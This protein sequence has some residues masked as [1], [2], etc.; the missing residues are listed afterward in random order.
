MKVKQAAKILSTGL[1]TLMMLCFAVTGL[2]IPLAAPNSTQIVVIMNDVANH[3]THDESKS[4]SPV[5][6]TLYDASKGACWTVPNPGRSI[7]AMPYHGYD[8]E[9]ANTGGMINGAGGADN[10]CAGSGIIKASITPGPTEYG[11][12]AYKS[13][14]TEVTINPKNF[15]TAILVIQDIAPKFEKGGNG[16][17]Q[18]GTIKALVFPAN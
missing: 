8:H 17:L 13:V 4:K 11:M 3:N 15:Y 2:A 10:A 6:F 9:Y 7:P 14:G 5:N 12:Q 1:A 18:Q 16:V